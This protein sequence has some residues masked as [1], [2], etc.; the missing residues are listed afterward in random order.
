MWKF[1]FVVSLYLYFRWRL[2]YQD[3]NWDPIYCAKHVAC[4]CLSQARTWIY[5]TIC[6]GLICVEVRVIIDI[7]GIVDRH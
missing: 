6:R 5:K 7:G 3:G 1:V 2:N 4:L